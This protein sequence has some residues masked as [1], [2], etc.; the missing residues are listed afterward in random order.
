MGN[1]VGCIFPSINEQKIQGIQQNRK[2]L[3]GI[4]DV[5]NYDVMYI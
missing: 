1:I 3:H 4:L 2:D 5:L